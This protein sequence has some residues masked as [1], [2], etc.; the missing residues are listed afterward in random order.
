MDGKNMDYSK[1]FQQ[2]MDIFITPEVKRRQDAGELPKPLNLI[3]AQIMF[4][5][6][7]RK[8][9]VRINS[10]VRALGKVKLKPE[11]SK[12]VGEPIY[13]H[14][15]EGLGAINLPEEDDPDCGHAT[16][17]RIGNS[18]TMA[19][20]FRYNKALSKKHI[21]AAQQFYDSA[22][23]SFEQKNWSPFIDNLFSASELLA[24]AILLSIPDPKFRKKATHQAIQLRY[25][26]FADLGN[27]KVEYKKTLNKLSG[28]RDKARY[29][30][31]DFSIT[32]E[33]AKTYLDTIRNMIEDAKSWTKT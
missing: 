32:E 23:F 6:D 3:A 20:D 29:L 26:R 1:A 27:V 5:P 17:L 13:E 12:K 18:W 28:L 9:K 8:S 15:I 21:E 31:E 11:I 10:E 24:K 7:G 30:K 2:L 14:E 19:F 22:Q 4:Y 25:N 16:L 33:Q